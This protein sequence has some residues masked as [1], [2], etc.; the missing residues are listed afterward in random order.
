[1]SNSSSSIL[2]TWKRIF[3]F[4]LLSL[5]V[6]L[7]ATGVLYAL[8]QVID[9]LPMALLYLLPVGLCAALWGLT[10]GIIAAIL[11]FLGL[12]YF[13]IEPRF[14]FFVHQSQDVIVLLVFLG[15]AIF[16]SQMV[17]RTRDSLAAAR[18]R[19]QEAVRLFRF[20]AELA[21]L[22]EDLAIAESIARNVR[23]TFQAM[24]VE[25]RIE[26]DAGRP[27]LIVRSPQN[28]IGAFASDAPVRVPLQ[29]PEQMLGE[30]RLFDVPA[31]LTPADERLLQT[32]SYE[33]V[34][35]L[36]RARL[37]QA[38]TRARVLEESDR[39]KSSLLSSVSHELRTPL[40][41][42]K[43]ASTSLSS[44][45]VAWDSEA[46]NELLDA[47]EE[48]TD[49]LNLLVGNLLDMSRI[50]SG[51]LNPQQHWSALDE[52]V[53]TVLRRMRTTLRNHQ[54]E[55]DVPRDLPLVYVDDVQ[56]GL[57]FTNL[58]SNSLKFAPENSVVGIHAIKKDGQTLEVRVLNQGPPVPDA[59]LELI[60]EKFH[61]VTSGNRVTGIGLGLSICKGIV[62][63]HGGRIWAENLPEGF[64][65]KFTLLTVWKG[66][67]PQIPEENEP[68]T[69]HPGD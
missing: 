46:R 40:S 31:D 69:T 22:H 6:T 65:I 32:F 35:A 4:S 51:A 19:E 66:Y 1:V 49:H 41:T 68:S 67:A 17:G 59:D 15:V 28:R 61:R 27:E 64:S 55:V 36:E 26:S 38:E 53:D 48:E 10:A 7:A 33:G 34:L 60:F 18:A 29:K 12:N 62:E 8:S 54:I 5:F 11:A 21:E 37:I 3:V 47:I 56:I 14:T 16:I 23:E 42:I 57:V 25:V 43:A 50:D 20:S 24:G 30:I 45:A 39:M 58:I 44:E 52:V 2:A 13:F 63:A 9:P